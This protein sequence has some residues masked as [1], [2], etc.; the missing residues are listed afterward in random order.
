[1]AVPTM[2]MLAKPPPESGRHPDE[3]QMALA[4]VVIGGELIVAAMRHGAHLSDG[5]LA[6]FVGELEGRLT[7]PFSF[8]SIKSTLAAAIEEKVATLP[9]ESK[10]AEHRTWE[11]RMANLWANTSLLFKGGVPWG[12]EM[13]LASGLVPGSTSAPAFS[14]NP[15]AK[16]ELASAPGGLG[17]MLSDWAKSSGPKDFTNWSDKQVDDYGKGTINY[18]DP[19]WF[20]DFNNWVTEDAK[21][22]GK[23]DPWSLDW[24]NPTLKRQLDKASKKTEGLDPKTLLPP[25]LNGFDT[26]DFLP[27]HREEQQRKAKEPMPNPEPE[28]ISGL[29]GQPSKPLEPGIAPEV[30]TSELMEGMRN[31]AVAEKPQEPQWGVAPE[32]VASE[33]QEDFNA[34]TPSGPSGAMVQAPAPASSTVVA[35]HD[36]KDGSAPVQ[37]TDKTAPQ[38]QQVAA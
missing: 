27:R 28:D 12:P 7:P 22:K 15:S 16:V 32:V 19:N 30:V 5:A 14:D 17:S 31:S 9:P 8:E 6:Q 34:R 4:R 13:A 11:E 29:S 24:N 3:N 1:M 37:G 18:K 33:M 38:P 25:E 23:S 20:K 36:K 21:R 35:S 10:T 2:G 26:K